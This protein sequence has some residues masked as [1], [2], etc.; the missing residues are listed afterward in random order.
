M[1]ETC[2]YCAG[3]ALE[4]CS[5][6]GK[7]L[8][9]DHTQRALPFLALGE[10]LKTIVQTLFRAP[11]TLP[12]LLTEAG[13]E[14]PFCPQCYRVNSQRRVQE[15]RKFIYLALALALVCVAAVVLLAVRPW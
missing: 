11:G 5:V 1:S 6:C 10:M 8:C 12:A 15:Q 14:E 2:A 13:E 4:K 3:D 9:R 7:P